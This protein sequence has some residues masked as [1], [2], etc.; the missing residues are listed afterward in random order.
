LIGYILGHHN[1]LYL[2]ILWVPQLTL[3]THS[4]GWHA[5]TNLVFIDP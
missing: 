2:L 5:A 1:D 4:F 3:Q